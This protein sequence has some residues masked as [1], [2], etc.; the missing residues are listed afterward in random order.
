MRHLLLIPIVFAALT[1][2]AH[3]LRA[4]YPGLALLAVAMPLLLLVRHPIA[5]R[6]VQG[7]LLAGAVE[8]IRTLAAILEIRKAFGEPWMRMALI[9]GAVALISALSALAAESWV[10]GRREAA[11]LVALRAEG[12]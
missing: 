5:L 10:R 4:G 6:I 2:G 3:L 8:W 12:I 1:Q 9:L 11:A 7:L